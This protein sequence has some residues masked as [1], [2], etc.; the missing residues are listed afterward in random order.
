M[1]IRI[2]VYCHDSRPLSGLCAQLQCAGYDVF[3]RYT[4]N[5]YLNLIDEE[6]IDIALLDAEAKETVPLLESLGAG[7]VERRHRLVLVAQQ[8]S[9]VSDDRLSALDVDDV[10]VLPV[11]R[12]DL[13]Y[14][15]RNIA[16]FASM[17]AEWVRRQQIFSDYDVALEDDRLASV[18]NERAR[19]LLVGAMGEEQIFLIDRLGGIATF[20]YAETADHA[21]H[22][23]RQDYVDI[24]HCNND[25]AANDIRKVSQ[26]IRQTNGL[27]DIP[28]LVSDHPKASHL[29][30]IARQEE[31]LNLMRVPTQAVGIQQH[32]QMLARQYRLKRQ[33]RGLSTDN[34][35][36]S[37]VDS[38]TRLYSRGFFYHYLEHALKQ[39][40]EQETKLSIATCTMHG[41]DDVNDML[42][43]P[44]G[45]RVIRELGKALAMSCRAQ[46]LVARIRG[47]SFCIALYDTMEHEARMACERV[48]EILR[49]II[50]S[51]STLLAHIHLNMGV[52]EATIGDDASQLVSKAFKQCLV[53]TLTTRPHREMGLVQSIMG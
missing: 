2:A 44:A 15:I 42:G 24:I 37:L 3:E 33:L 47:A 34:L 39:S 5:A 21:L 32:V 12:D 51:D 9:S 26:E 38:L 1:S 16:R 43:Y 48:N 17:K 13:R 29:V 30:E 52:A 28:I 8:H 10:I 14:R 20:T 49:S 19:I 36:T 46:D 35:Y 4:S 6:R 45:D 40:H 27:T 41:L 22:L 50:G 11:P 7:K 53:S 25:M 23:L 31:R 18:T